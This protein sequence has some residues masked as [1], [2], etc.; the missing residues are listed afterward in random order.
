VKRGKILAIVLST[1]LLMAFV[2]PSTLAYIV[3]AVT[4]L[5]NTFVPDP[6]ALAQTSVSISA[7][8]T[9]LNT[10]TEFIGPENF[11][12]ILKN[13]ATQEEVRAM[14]DKSGLAVF[15]LDYN[16]LEAGRYSY[17]LSEANN[18]REGV[19]YSD[20]VYQ[21]DVIVLQDGDHLTTK[22]LLDGVETPRCV[23]PFEN[24][25]AVGK[26]E[27]PTGDETPLLLCSVL[28]LLSGA[29]VIMLVCRQ[30]KN[31]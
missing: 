9:V 23:A 8:K 19:A 6:R 29:A 25:Y 26:V 22:V 18:G 28:M 11:T 16:G 13:T 21:I 15:E 7:K 4:P 3:T 10:G 17:T 31:G 30:R 24:I 1:M 20:L 14:S 2:L 5:K 27:P 12:F